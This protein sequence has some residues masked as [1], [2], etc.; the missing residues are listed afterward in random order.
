MI[1][2][3]D[4]IDHMCNGINKELSNTKN[5]LKKVKSRYEKARTE[6]QK[7]SNEV[8]WTKEQMKL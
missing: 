5:I 1:Y 7:S 8:E 4:T 2:T 3:S 6:L